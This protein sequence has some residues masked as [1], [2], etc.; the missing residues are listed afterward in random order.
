MGCSGVNFGEALLKRLTLGIPMH[1]EDVTGVLTHRSL[2]PPWQSHANRWQ[3]PRM[4]DSVCNI[5]AVLS[6]YPI[7]NWNEA[8]IGRSICN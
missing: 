6:H 5:F 4:L 1:Y 7:K 3:F 2:E 8:R